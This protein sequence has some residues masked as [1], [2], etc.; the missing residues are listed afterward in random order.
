M[1]TTFALSLS[2]LLIVTGKKTKKERLVSVTRFLRLL[3]H[4][5][6]PV[7]VLKHHRRWNPFDS[8]IIKYILVFIQE[9]QIGTI[10]DVTLG[11]SISRLQMPKAIHP[12][13]KRKLGNEVPWDTKGTNVLFLFWTLLLAQVSNL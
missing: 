5:Y 2:K 1:T 7:E 11:D 6:Q 4:Q 8:P 9:I 13:R 3:Q 10:V 12:D